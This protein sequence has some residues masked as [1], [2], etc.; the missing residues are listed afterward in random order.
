MRHHSWSHDVVTFIAVLCFVVLGLVGGAAVAGAET[1]TAAATGAD[2]PPDGGKPAE[3]ATVPPVI[4]EITVTATRFERAIDLTPKTV[5][6][7]DE[8]AIAVRPMTNVQG[9]IDDVPGIAVARGGGLQ[10]QLVVRGLASNDSR[11]VLFVDGDR[12][13]R[14]RPSIEYNFLDPNEIE[15][16]EIVRGPASALYGSDAM[17]GVVNFITR[18]GTGD[19]FLP[20][21]ASLGYGSANSLLA[22]R[23]AVSGQRQTYDAL[24]GLNYRS[25]GDYDTPRGEI[26]NTD[27]TTRSLNLR[28]GWSPDATRRLELNGK[29]GRFTEGRAGAPNAPTIKVREEPLEEQSLRLG[30]TQSQ[31]APWISDLQ[32]SLFV[33]EVNTFIRGINH[34]FT[35]GNVETRDTWVIGPTGV[36]GKLLARSALG[37]N[38]IAYGVDVYHED[39]PSFE[40]EVRLVNAAGQPISSDPR[41][42]RVRDAT[43]SL[44]GVFAHY[45]WDASQ[46]FT[47]SLGTRYDL[48]RTE[49]DDKPAVGENP[50][51]TAAYAGKLESDDDKVTGSVGLIFRLLDSFHLVANA[52][53]AFRAPTTFDKS[54]SGVVGAILTIPNPDVQP[55]ESVTYE[56]GARVR[57]R[58]FDANLTA[59]RT[60]YENLLQ[61]VF[62]NPTT[63][64]RIN[65]GEAKTEG[66]ELDGVW[67]LPRSL[68]LRFN[69][70]QVH[71]TNTLTHV[72]LPYVPPLSGLVALRYTPA[73][74]YWVE[75]AGRWSR[76]KTRI[77]RTQER[78]TEGYEVWSLYAG[79]DLGHWS[80]RLAPF[81]LTVGIDNL[82]DE[83]YVSPATREILSLPRSRTNPLLE[84]GR[85]LTVNL[86]SGF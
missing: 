86:T 53:T 28:F 52:S 24:L 56:S 21:L 69:A 72:P 81:R 73:R 11:T 67:T 79:A 55:E 43:Q 9:T 46:R 78:T 84:P 68:S 45:D 48:T 33:R 38:L 29:V 2:T 50:A 4:E 6:V 36:G 25:A 83:D 47:A 75:A 27:F 54:G 31:V 40:D 10:G 14:G 7:V 70:A 16:I 39:V 15:R 30:Y 71:G 23:V 17:N 19:S 63:R 1:S 85:S 80:P 60:D 12:F 57:L 59:F 58:T 13:G 77:D 42:K 76:A 49:L 74:A 18:R 35:N 34:G 20:R 44:F 61:T 64:Q 22:A 26:P 8:A 32:T 3:A 37:D 41:A 5:S 66:L 51:L 62:L 82:T 65:I